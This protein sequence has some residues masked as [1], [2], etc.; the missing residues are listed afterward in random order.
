MTRNISR[1]TLLKSSLAAGAT[2]PW[3]APAV[4]SAK[5]KP[6]SET[7]RLAGIGVGGKGWT[8]IRS[9]ARHGQ[10]IAFCDV[11]TGKNRRG[12]YGAAAEQWPQA[13]RYTDYRKLLD[14]EHKRLDGITV[15]TPDHM[16][17]PITM[18]ALQLGL[19][20]Y[21]QKPLTRTVH[22]ARSLTLAAEKAGVST[23]MGNQHH[24]GRG[25]RT[26]VEIVRGGRLG[27]I[28]AAHTWSN[29]P[30]WPQGIDR[31]EGSDPVPKTLDWD[32][33]LGVAPKRP[34]KRGVYHPFK[35]RGWYDF[36]AGA[37]GDMGCHIID[38]AVWSLELKPAKSVAYTGP[39]PN[40]ETFPKWEVLHY[41]FH[42]TQ[43]T[44]PGEFSM[45]WYDGGK[46]PST[47]GTHL[48]DGDKLPSQGVMLVGTEGTL[49][50]NHGGSPQLYPQEKF[51]D[52]KLP[53]AGGL[54]HYGTWADGIRSGSPPNSSFAYSGPLTETVL[55]G[56][57]AS[58]VGEGTLEWDSEKLTFT[59]SEQ[60][61]QFVR[62]EYRPRW[63]VKGL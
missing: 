28:K 63:E 40:A 4:L 9:A 48:S 52:V 34:Y 33:W 46:R 43:Y 41:R 24:S 51:R 29:R 17:A 12:G 50:C 56:V 3:A 30:I 26:L 36:G 27:K 60:A 16:H 19:A 32:L 44:T 31:P 57:V 10:V 22:E 45:W 54:D 18:A 20:V 21:T 11:D 38:P 15:S 42:G 49:L 58:R 55:L 37:L 13:A 2:L 61:N 1:R 25:Y 5:P 53:T 23:Q 62:D 47:E 8:D 7:L 14:K 35:S 39:T 59:N 6:P